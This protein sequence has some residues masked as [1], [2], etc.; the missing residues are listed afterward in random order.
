MSIILALIFFTI[1]ITVGYLI[2]RR[3]VPAT[4]K[5]VVDK[6]GVFALKGIFTHPGHTWVEVVEPDLVNVGMDRFTKSVFGSINNIKVPA[7]G[8][9]I[10]QGGKAWTVERDGRQL[11][12]VSPISGKVVE[13]NRAILNDTKIMND[14]N[15]ERNWILKIEPSKLRKELRNLLYGDMAA[16]WNQLAKEQLVSVLVPAGFP[17]LQDGGDISPNL[18]NE[19]PDH[20][21][22]KLTKEFFNQI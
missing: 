17:V 20:E 14:R 8:E 5:V 3:N 19:L 13:V 12:Q 16:R 18:G 7:K 15:G 9:T 21:W 22:E 10:N 6:K 1:V 11:H 2:N 4:E